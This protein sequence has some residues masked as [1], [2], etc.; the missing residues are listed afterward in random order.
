[1]D[2]GFKKKSTFDFGIRPETEISSIQ[3]SASAECKQCS[4][5]SLNHYFVVESRARFQPKDYTL[6][7]TGRRKLFRLKLVQVNCIT[8]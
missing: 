8:M 5:E 6:L 3:P 4:S 7:Q 2:K 1:M